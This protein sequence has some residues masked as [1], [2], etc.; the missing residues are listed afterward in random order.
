VALGNL[1]VKNDFD[2]VFRVYQ[3]AL[4]SDVRR[5]AAFVLYDNADADNWQMLFDAW[6]ND[7]LSRHRKWACELVGKFGFVEHKQE[8]EEM[9][10][11]KD[12]HV[13][14]AAKKVLLKA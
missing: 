10:E 11:G 2:A 12:G 6:K 14:A 8:V 9:L 5:R 13:R 4:D 1:W 3:T 7:S